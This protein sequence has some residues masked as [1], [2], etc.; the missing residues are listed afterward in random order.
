[1]L[2]GLLVATAKSSYDSE[3]TEV[4]QMAADIAFLDR[5]L[6]GYG[7]EARPAREAPSRGEPCD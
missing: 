5:L 6:A 4:T 2:L 1:M 7:S 3:K